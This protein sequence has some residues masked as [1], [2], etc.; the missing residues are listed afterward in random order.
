MTAGTITA[1]AALVAAVATPLASVLVQG[2]AF[3]SGAVVTVGVLLLGILLGLAMVGK[4][5]IPRLLGLGASASPPSVEQETS[6]APQRLPK[7]P[8]S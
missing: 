6:A 2:A 1:Y 4:G 3:S 8:D 7:P 5:P